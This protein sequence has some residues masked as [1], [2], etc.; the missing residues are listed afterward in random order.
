MNCFL[1]ELAAKFV[2]VWEWIQDRLDI[3]GD[4]VM[5]GFTGAVV[6]KML[7]GKLTPADAAAY[8]SAIA[9]FGYSNASKK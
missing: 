3:S 5:L 9:A 4:V 8:G 6:F 1:E 2:L 7:Y